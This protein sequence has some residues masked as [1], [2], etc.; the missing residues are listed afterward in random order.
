MAALFQKKSA[1][2][3]TSKKA[4]SSKESLVESRTKETLIYRTLLRPHMTEKAHSGLALNKYVFQVNTG[5]DKGSVRRAVEA[6]YGVHVE[7][8]RIVAM[9]RRARVFRGR[10]GTQSATKKA[11][12]TVREGESIAL[13]QTA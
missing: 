2:T 10:V 12:V 1:S 4:V 11:I 5:A 7:Q 9:A 3:K 8:V 13:F 6:A